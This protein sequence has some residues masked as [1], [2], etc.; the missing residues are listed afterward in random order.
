VLFVSRNFTLGAGV[1]EMTPIS[2]VLLIVLGL[3]F[4]VYFGL[5]AWRVSGDDHAEITRTVLPGNK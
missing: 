4:T 3:T 1:R 2:Y 5:A